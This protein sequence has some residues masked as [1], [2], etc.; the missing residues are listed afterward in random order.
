MN[1]INN[2]IKKSLIS[3]SRFSG[4]PSKIKPQGDLLNT[5]IKQIIHQLKAVEQRA[6]VLHLPRIV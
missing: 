3:T 2:P 6:V 1:K 4:L 5:A